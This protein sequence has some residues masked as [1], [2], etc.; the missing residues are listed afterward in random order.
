MLPALTTAEGV[1]T[2]RR[3][4]TCISSVWAFVA[5]ALRTFVG[6][7]GESRDRLVR[8]TALLLKS[9]LHR[10]YYEVDL[11]VAKHPADDPDFYTALSE[12][13]RRADLDVDG[14]FSGSDAE[15]LQFLS[16]LANYT[17]LD[18][19]AS[20]TKGVYSSGGNIFGMGVW[21]VQGDKDPVS[22]HVV[23][24]ECW[25]RSG[26]CIAAVARLGTPSLLFPDSS[27]TVGTNYWDITSWSDTRVEAE[28]TLSCHRS[29]LT[30][31]AATEQAY[32][33]QTPLSKGHEIC[34]RG[35]LPTP[36]VLTLEGG[37]DVRRRHRKETRT[38]L[39]KV[40]KFPYATL[41]EFEE[42]FSKP[43]P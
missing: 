1:G 9:M 31:D 27:L 17:D 12:F 3:A 26:L 28:R 15:R 41:E 13:E 23:S 43:T 30:L 4:A 16:S 14:T 21:V 35:E 25:R 38:L 7:E 42:F 11:S 37:A 8:G 19:H 39:S 22:N 2:S 6:E 33:V 36:R 32:E 29:V 24:V 5:E 10:L 40:S 20:A 18:A 34:A